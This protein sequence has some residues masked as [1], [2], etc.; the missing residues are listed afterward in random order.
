MVH[1]GDSDGLSGLLHEQVGIAEAADWQRLVL[2]RFFEEISSLSLITF[3]WMDASLNSMTFRRSQATTPAYAGSTICYAI[4]KTVHA[5]F[6]CL[7]IKGVQEV[8]ARKP[9]H[10]YLRS[11]EYQPGCRNGV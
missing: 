4:D 2:E 8:R 1:G 10:C 7:E 5:L 11:H 6:G 3:C 9:S